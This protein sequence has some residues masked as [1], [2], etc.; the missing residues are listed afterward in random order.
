MPR[1]RGACR[2][3]RRPRSCVALRPRWRKHR[4]RDRQPAF[5]P[6]YYR[7]RNP[8]VSG[9]R[10]QPVPSLPRSRPRGRAAWHQRRL[11]TLAFD[12]QR[13]DASRET[14]L[15]F[16]HDA[17]RTGAPIIA[18]N[19]ALRLQQTYNVV[20][21][22]LG[23]GELFPVFESC[24]AAV[25][26]PIPHTEWC[27][28][29]ARHLVTRLCASYRVLY[30]IAN[31]IETRMVLPALAH[32]HVPV[33]TLVHEFASY[34]RPAGSMGQALDWSTQVVFPAALVAGAAQKEHPTLRGRTIHVLPQGPCPAPLAEGAREA[35]PLVDALLELRRQK[36]REHALVVFGCGTVH[37]RKGVDLFLS[38]AAAVA[39]L[40]PKRPVRFVW[41][42]AG[43]RA[44]ARSLLLVLSR[45]PNRTIRTGRDHVDHR[46]HRRRGTGVC[47]G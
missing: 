13:L 40:G 19:I 47:A 29:E 1:L 2:R 6:E 11:T 36:E 5:D 34:T 42:G 9:G 10:D 43:Y 8:D 31:S 35:A 18:Y 45:G 26:G 25:V 15:L 27:D 46:C 32:A 30:A 39:R 16:A 21:V 17:S 22:L 38:C 33:V 28:V 41:I 44:G 4:A 3:S 23:A 7:H 37:L 14:I 20:A 24:C 12:R